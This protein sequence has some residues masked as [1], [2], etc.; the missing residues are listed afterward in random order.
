M[1]E[2]LRV[3]FGADDENPCVAAV[4]DYLES[5]ATILDVAHDEPPTSEW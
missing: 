1:S 3:A 5:R 2:R 4:R